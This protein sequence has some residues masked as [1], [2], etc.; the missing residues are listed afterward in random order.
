MIPRTICILGLF[1]MLIYGIFILVQSPTRITHYGDLNANGSNETYTLNNGS[2]TITEKGNLLWQS[3]KEWW[4]DSFDLGDLTHDEIIDLN[5]S[6]WKAGNYGSSKPFWVT[7]NDQSIKNHFFVFNVT[8]RG[9][10]PVW[11]SSNLAVPNCDFII[12]DIDTDGKMELITI[13]G[14]YSTGRTCSGT[15]R[16]VWKWNGWGFVN[17]SRISYK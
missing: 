5:L 13:E 6:V 15:H 2:I 10:K 1:C 16:A 3:P 14:E 7:E 12:A 8:D 11:Q 17:E 4:I 9:V